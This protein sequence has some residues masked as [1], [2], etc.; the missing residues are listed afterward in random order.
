V[1]FDGSKSFILREKIKFDFL[2]SRVFNVWE[3]AIWFVKQI[4]I[5]WKIFGN[6]QKSNN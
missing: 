5:H 6:F 2:N 4:N 1:T 3:P